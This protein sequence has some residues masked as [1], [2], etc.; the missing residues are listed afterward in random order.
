M[1]SDIIRANSEGGNLLGRW[2]REFSSESE[3][4]IQAYY[5]RTD[6]E[7][8][9]GGEVRNTFDLDAQ[10]RFR[11]G[12]RHEIIWGAGYRY[13]VD[14]VAGSPDFRLDQPS[15]GLQ[16]GSTFVQ[17]V[18]A[19]IPDRLSLTAGTKLEHNDFTGFELQPSV[20]LA[21]TPD[22]H[23]TVWGSISRAVRTPSRAERGVHLYADPPQSAPQS[24]LPL[25]VPGM[26][27]PEFDSEELLASE[28][29]L[30]VSVHPRLSLDL[31]AF[32][33][34]YDRLYNVALLPA[35]LRFSPSA[36]P[37]LAFPITDGNALYGETYGAE[38]SAIWQPLDHWRLRA[39]YTLLRMNL[40]TRGSVPSVSEASEG[41]S[42]RHQASLW[43]DL[44]LG[45]HVEWGVG[46]RYVDALWAQR[47][48]AYVQVETRL[49]W[50]PTLNCE[51]S[52]VGRNLFDAHHQE[53]SPFLFF[54]RNV[55]VDRAVYGKVVFRF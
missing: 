52:I 43:S 44:D 15:V 50:K 51:I 46:L 14:D 21:W 27:N 28:I 9:I 38:M 10:Y 20:R 18:V 22:E 31:A 7:F 36:Q 19:L 6:R 1:Y 33:N 26:G 29:G 30:R 17:D 41:E 54:A 16:L 42:P 2:T 5:D 49:A 25:L 32:Y 23:H 55:E 4:T 48:P 37:Y 45:R 47:I 53:F 11:L 12:E 8:G 13:S 24:P 3:L 35:E 39:Q 34:D 40:R